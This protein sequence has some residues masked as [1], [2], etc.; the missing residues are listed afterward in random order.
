[1][2]ENW[3]FAIFATFI[4]YNGVSTKGWGF[5]ALYIPSF[6]E[7]AYFDKWNCALSPKSVKFIKSALLKFFQT[8]SNIV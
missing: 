4:G 3:P 2:E 7:F 6:Y 5:S 1:M 8:N